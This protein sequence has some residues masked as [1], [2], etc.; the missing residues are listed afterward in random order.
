[1]RTRLTLLAVAAGLLGAAP[2]LASNGITPIAPANGATVPV[3][4]APTFKMRVH[5]PGTVWVVVCKSAKRHKDG[6]ICDSQTL[7]RARRSHGSLFTFK[8]KFF[9]FPGFWLVTPG[10]YY[11]QAYRIHCTT[12]LDDCRQE[13]TV[14]RFEIG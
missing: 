13:G 7:G 12:N 11:W 2:A 4:K 1:M 6:T 14:T 9:D 5:G 3:G 8:P 10:T